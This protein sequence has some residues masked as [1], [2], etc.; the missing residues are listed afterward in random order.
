MKK[1]SHSPQ[2]DAVAAVKDSAEDP[3]SVI[4]CISENCKEIVTDSSVIKI[5][6]INGVAYN[7][8]ALIDTGS[9][10]SFISAS[11]FKTF[12]DSIPIL[13]EKLSKSYKALN[14][15]SIAISGFFAS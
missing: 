9:P 7:S 6:E 5:V 8:L 12:F 3:S 11:A 4:A 14:D 2:S 13:L 10:I 15:S 1:S